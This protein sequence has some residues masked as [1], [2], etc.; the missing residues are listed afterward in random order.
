MLVLMQARLMS[1]GLKK[2]RWLSNKSCKIPPHCKRLSKLFSCIR[3]QIFQSHHYFS[4]ANF[5]SH[6][7]LFLVQNLFCRN[8]KR[9]GKMQLHNIRDCDQTLL[10]VHFL[11][12]ISERVDTFYPFEPGGVIDFPQS[13][14]VTFSSVTQSIS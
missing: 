2:I 14:M 8:C 5:N 13:V 1:F 7:F 12:S 3:C 11:I 10:Q 4:A 9:N 6:S